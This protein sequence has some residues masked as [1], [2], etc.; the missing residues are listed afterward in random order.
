MSR[1]IAATYDSHSVLRAVDN[2]TVVI[3]IGMAIAMGLTGLYFYEAV[4]VGVSQKTFAC[5][6][7]ATLWFLP[8]DFSFVLH[9]NEWFNVYDHWLPK[10]WC[11]GLVGT[12][13]LEIFLL[14][15]VIRYGRKEIMPMMSQRVFA[16]LIIAATFVVGCVWFFIRTVLDDPLFYV[17][18]FLTIVWPV[19]FTTPQLLKRRSRQGTSMLQ[20]ACLAP[21][22]WGLY[23]ALWNMD[24]WF[25]RPAFAIMVVAVSLW[26][27]FNMWLLSRQPDVAVA[28]RAAQPQPVAA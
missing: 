3:A 6:L 20:Q 9:W 17:S 19:L 15:Q 12:V 10:V 13:G 27:F 5:P 24:D 23:L 25:R 7:V 1:L 18:F 21:M 11:I 16:A 28:D 2:H 22:M 4:R 26:Q 8:H 14:G